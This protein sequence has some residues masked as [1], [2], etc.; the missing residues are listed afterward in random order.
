M[1]RPQTTTTEAMADHGARVLRTIWNLVSS[2]EEAQDVFQETFL[3]HHL[4][5]TRGRTIDN[6]AAWLCTT[7]RH[8]AFRLRRR[9]C[10]PGRRV[11][12]ELLADLPAPASDPH[13]RI[14]LERLRDLAARLPERQA[15]VFTMRNFEQLSFA[16]I[17]AHLDISE[18]AARASA[19]K[20]LQKLREQ[21]APAKEERHVG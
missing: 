18:D 17:A 4:A 13:H 3:Q 12:E 7:A 2:A 19:H 8:A 16:E 5:M 21:M 9:K 1:A 11:P 14:V 20:A 10:G 6:T 15:Q